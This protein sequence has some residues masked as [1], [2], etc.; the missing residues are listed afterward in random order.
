MWERAR[1]KWY[2][3]NYQRLHRR[4]PHG[5]LRSLS[6]EARFHD[7]AWGAR[8][9]VAWYLRGKQMPTVHPFSEALAVWDGRSEELEWI[10]CRRSLLGWMLIH[11]RRH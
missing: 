8:E 4:V 5:S 1:A 6:A 3:K 7:C 2:R 9:A 10:A 11:V